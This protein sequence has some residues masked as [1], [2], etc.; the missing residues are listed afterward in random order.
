MV[1]GAVA[2]LLIQHASDELRFRDHP[3]L[4]IH[5]IESYIAVPLNRRD[6]SYFGTLCALDSIPAKLSED[7][8]AILNLL[9]QL[10]AFELEADEQQRACEADLRAQED[11]I[12]IAAHD[13]RQP[14]TALYGRAQLLA[15]HARQ[16]GLAETLIPGIETL[17]VQT[18]R[19]VQLSE[20][21]L[22]IARLETGEFELSREWFNLVA[23]AQQAVD[24]AQIN[25]PAHTF[26]FNAPPQLMFY[27][28]ASRLGQVLRNLLDNAAK[29]TPAERG[30]VEFTVSEERTDDEGNIVQ[31][32]VLDAG[33][34]VSAD[35][36]PHLFERRFRAAN[37][38]AS[39]ISGTGLGLYITRQ[40][41]EAHGGTIRAERATLGGL[42]ICLVLPLVVAPL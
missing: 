37:A 32:S 35:D 17:V 23:L 6:G 5:G 39:G 13:L 11:F 7:D 12:A 22:D 25:T 38:A 42:A 16:G 14:L 9:A 31:I 36:L 26:I 8:F 29:Y 30:A 21:L 18:R 40:I 24:D 19:S 20:N 3:G 1:G 28:D 10:I 33:I 15:R 27:G 4:Q 41:V 2:P 34:G